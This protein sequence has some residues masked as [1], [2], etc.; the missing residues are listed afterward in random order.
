MQ[1]VPT[2][3]GDH[4]TDHTV[5]DYLRPPVLRSRADIEDKIRAAHAS[6]P[7]FAQ[8]DL[9]GVHLV[10]KQCGFHGGTPI[11]DHPSSTRSALVQLRRGDGR[12]CTHNPAGQDWDQ[13]TELL[14]DFVHGGEALVTEALTCARAAAADRRAAEKALEIARQAERDAV[15]A[16]HA[17]GASKTRIGK[18]I[19]RSPTVIGKWLH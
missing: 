17:A 1:M 18:V 2:S 9:T 11:W 6:S 5:P 8:V 4:Q 16:A 10:L 14:T 12:E 13:L 15:V 19:D 7:D 3:S